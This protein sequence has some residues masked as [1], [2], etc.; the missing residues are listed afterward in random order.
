[1]LIAQLPEQDAADNP[2]AAQDQQQN[3]G[4]VS[5][6]ARHNLNKRLNIAVGRVMGGH[7]NHGQQI[8]A[9]Q[10]RSTHQQRKTFQRAGVFAGQFWQ[11]FDQ[12]HQGDQRPHADGKEGGAPAEVL[13]HNA[14]DR[15]A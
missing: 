15:Q 4:K 3:G 8:D 1:M 6:K 9:H 7:H 11:Q 13:T 14:P 2:R 5:A 12:T 10:R